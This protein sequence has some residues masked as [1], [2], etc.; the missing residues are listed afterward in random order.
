MTSGNVK[1]AQKLLVFAAIILI[2]SPAA[3]RSAER[4]Y[5]VPDARL[6]FG[7]T[8]SPTDA[9]VFLF[10]ASRA[11]DEELSSGVPAV[12]DLDTSK[13]VRFAKFETLQVDSN[14]VWSVDGQRAIFETTEGV[15]EIDS[16]RLAEPPKTV[17]K[18][19]T[20]GIA[21]S[22]DESKLAFWRV[23][24]SSWELIVRDAKTTS[25]V[26]KWTV[27]FVYG[28]EA[29]GF[30]ISFEAENKLYAR[31]FDHQGSTPLK[32]FDI[33]TGKVETVEHDCLALA[34]GG[35][36]TY[37]IVSMGHTKSLKKVMPG[38]EIRTVASVGNFD[39][40][41]TSAGGKWIA[42]SGGGKSGTLETDTDRISEKINCGAVTILADG[43]SVF[44][45]RGLLSSSAAVC[46]GSK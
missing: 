6:V 43:T 40:L 42:L 21:L 37:Y 35:G 2:L 24:K 36:T 11:D 16:T 44:V 23:G 3:L 32:R 19:P 1:R 18:G 29:T 25:T 15:F 34:S 26:R 7:L 13:I 41:R 28:G 5:K 33:S 27:P 9:K 45:H 46:G 31:T 12:V 14:V 10:S 4:R 22:G 38:G 39:D 30:E 17:A 8:A 20:H